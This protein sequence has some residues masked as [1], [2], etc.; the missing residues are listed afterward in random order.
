VTLVLVRTCGIHMACVLWIVITLTACTFHDVPVSTT[1]G[2]GTR[3]DE[4]SFVSARFT[5]PSRP[6]CFVLLFKNKTD[7]DY[8]ERVRDATG[9]SCH[10]VVRAAKSGAVVITRQ[11]EAKFIEFTNWYSPDISIAV[12]VSDATLEESLTSG[13]QYDVLMECGGIPDGLGAPTLI[14]RS[15]DFRL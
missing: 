8:S 15:F 1:L 11:V 9:V 10:I 3:H 2:I 14:L 7:I 12:Y 6:Y 5:C 4:Q 13:V